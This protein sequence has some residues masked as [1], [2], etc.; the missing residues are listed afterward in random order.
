MAKLL[1]TLQAACNL[2]AENGNRW[3]WYI[4]HHI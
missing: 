4:Y 2:S 3:R 1:R